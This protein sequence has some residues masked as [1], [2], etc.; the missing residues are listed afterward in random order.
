MQAKTK[1]ETTPLQND[2]EL[3][4]F[5]ALLKV[6]QV[7]SYLEIGG[8]FGGSLWTIGNSLPA[9]SRIVSVDL[10]H[11]KQRYIE[12]LPHLQQCVGA[13]KALGY[14]AHLIIGDSTAPGIIAQV[15]ALG[16]YD[17]CLIDANHTEPFVRK[18]WINYGPLCRIVAFHDVNH[19]KWIPPE[20]I[21]I[22][23]KKVWD[24]LKVDHRY[25]EIKHDPDINGIGVLWR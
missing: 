14:D 15:R 8:K 17:A 5:I 4:D 2:R 25:C 12:E 22:Q 6:E 11:G 3:R 1:Y 7:K 13:L 24:E 23:V 20:R 10:P 19:T 16:P 21:P 18:D 9:G